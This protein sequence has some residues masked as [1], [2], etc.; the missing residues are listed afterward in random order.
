MK[1]LR[2]VLSLL[3]A[4]M[5]TMMDAQGVMRAE[6]FI[7]T[8]PGFGSATAIENVGLGE[9]GYVL[10]LDGVKA[11]TH[12]LYI[13]AQDE[14][15]H[16]SPTVARPLYVESYRGFLRL[17]YFYD[18]ADPSPGNATPLPRPASSIGEILCSLPTTGLPLGT[19]TLNVRGMR[20]NGT[21][22]D[23]V[24]RQ[25]LIVE[26]VGP[27]EK[28]NLEY[29]L[30]NDPGYGQGWSVAATTGVNHLALDI[31]GVSAGAHILYIRCKDEQGRWSPTVSHPLYVCRYPDMVAIEYY[32]DQ[33]DPGEG[34]AI[35]VALP[36]DKSADLAFDVSLDGL[37][38][39]QHQL[40]IRAKDSF[41]RWMLIGSEPFTIV[42]KETG[43]RDVVSDFSFNIRTIDSRCLITAQGEN[44]RGECQ[45]EVYSISGHRVAQSLWKATEPQLELPLSSKTGNVILIKI[46]DRKDQRQFVRRLIVD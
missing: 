3:A 11:G 13:R 36:N 10:S 43:I 1:R 17:E 14:Q 16:W 41:G 19:H 20:Q 39:G 22:N 32:F 29:F 27:V 4:A 12:I 15:G 31:G 18:D 38:L 5:S 33:A 37:S 25:F 44:N 45:V 28:G 42:Q 46:I 6:Y 26:Y 2:I 23:I 30:D 34:R 40:N 21:W 35:Q 8:D 7:D 9:K 24:S